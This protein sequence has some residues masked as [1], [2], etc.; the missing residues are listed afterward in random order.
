M[1]TKFD[2]TL[3]ASNASDATFRAWVQFIHDLLITTGG[4][5]DPGDTGQL[6]ISTAAHPTGTSQKVGYRMYRMADT[7]QSTSPVYMKVYYGS[8]SLGANN[9]GI[10]VTI[11]TGSDGT[12]TI[13]SIRY[14]EVQ[15]WMAG[16]SASVSNSYGSA[17]TNRVHFLLFCR[18]GAT[19]QFVFSLERAKNSD[20][21]GADIGD[22]L[23]ITYPFSAS[24]AGVVQRTQY[25]NLLAGGQPPVEAGL[26]LTISNQASSSFSSNTG[27]GLVVHFKGV[28]QPPGTG[29][30][31]V[32]D[33]D[34]LAAAQFTMTL[35]GA[36]RT[37]QLSDST[38]SSQVMVPT[39]NGAM[40]TRSNTRV[41]IRY[42]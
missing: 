9:P 5:V 27:V 2:A 23:Y 1:A 42:D 35:Y 41:G 18:S 26:S 38:G 21:S 36:T 29:L 24:P 22:G 11:G 14:G 25:I 10:W 17:A 20:G 31:F 3:S 28:A 16:V 4:W 19:D 37:Y 30:V 15:Y 13:T 39:G 12:G 7:L 6:T 33:G 40:T 34:C 32:N 8:N